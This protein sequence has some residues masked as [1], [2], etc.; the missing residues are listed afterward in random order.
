MHVQHSPTGRV[1][2]LAL[3][4]EVDIT[5]ADSLR[6]SL[7]EL[8]GA[9]LIV[10]D[11]AGVTALDGTVLGVLAAAATRA[12]AEGGRLIVVNESGAPAKALRITGLD[13][14]LCA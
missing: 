4:G 13:R 11:L 9:P 1:A 10:V 8:L 14:V 3:Q 6:R 2:V 5:H 12:E 7:L